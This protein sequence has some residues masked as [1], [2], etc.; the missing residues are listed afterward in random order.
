MKAD[1]ALNLNQAREYLGVSEKTL[2]NYCK[3]SKIAFHHEKNLRGVMEYRFRK[4]DL[5]DFLTRKA[6][7]S[8]SAGKRAERPDARKGA[9]S[10]ANDGKPVFLGDTSAAG[11]TP[12]TL[13]ATSATTATTDAIGAIGAIGAID[14]IGA[15][16]PTEA[17]S[18]QLHAAEAWNQCSE[19]GR[20][21]VA[22]LQAEVLFLKEQ[23][24]EKDRQIALKDKQLERH[25]ERI[26]TLNEHLS[27]LALGKTPG[28]S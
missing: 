19:L 7:P 24:Q 4:A 23:L 26:S 12:Q 14:A 8:C 10:L 20:Q 9:E 18:R 3:A 6:Q 16:A 27:S 13:T 28:D 2:R 25:M 17:T 11:K 5:D 1:A 15:T 21:L 22:Q